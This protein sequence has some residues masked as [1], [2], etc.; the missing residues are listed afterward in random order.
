M[1]ASQVGLKSSVEQRAYFTSS[2]TP[3]MQ[4]HAEP[5]IKL[6]RAAYVA[7]NARDIDAA[8]ATMTPDVAWSKAF[9]GG[10]VRGH[11]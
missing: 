5:E 1:N 2:T 6:L 11:K 4:D 8:L 3:H 10:S 9:K 7:F